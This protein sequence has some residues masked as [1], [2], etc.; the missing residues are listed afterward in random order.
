MDAMRWL[1]SCLLLVT[2]CFVLFMPGNAQWIKANGPEGGTVNAILVSGGDTVIIGLEYGGIYRSTDCGQSWEQSVV[3]D[4]MIYFESI[5]DIVRLPGGELFAA[6]FSS[7]DFSG[8]IY[9][10]TDNGQ[11][12]QR[13]GS[14]LPTLFTPMALTYHPGTGSIFTS[15][16]FSTDN[17]FRSTDSGVSWAS[18]NTGLPIGEVLSLAVDSLNNKIYAA[19]GSS[20]IYL[21]TNNGDNWSQVSTGL[22]STGFTDVVVD[23]NGTVFAG[24]ENWGAGIFRSTD[25]G[26]SWTNVGTSLL[27][28][29]FQ[30]MTKQGGSLVAVFYNSTCPADSCN[31]NFIYCSNDDGDSWSEIGQ[32]F[33]GRARAIAA[34]DSILLLGTDLGMMKLQ[35][36]PQLTSAGLSP[37]KVEQR[38]LLPCAPVTEHLVSNNGLDARRIVALTEVENRIFVAGPGSSAYSTD[39]G[40]SWTQ[41]TTPIDAQLLDFAPTQNG[42]VMAVGN[43]GSALRGVLK[44]AAGG[45]TWLAVSS[46]IDG[47]YNEVEWNPTLQINAIVS[48][49]SFIFLSTDGGASFFQVNNGLPNPGTTTSLIYESVRQ[50]AVCT[51]FLD[52]TYDLSPSLVWQQINPTP[53]Y[54]VVSNPTTGDL[55]VRTTPA[56]NNNTSVDIYEYLFSG[57][58]NLL[59]GL[60]PSV[61]SVFRMVY[62][63][64]L[65]VATR[66]NTGRKSS[67][68]KYTPGAASATWSDISSGLPGAEVLSMTAHNDRLFVGTQGYGIWSLDLTTDVDEE[69]GNPTEYQLFQNYPNP[70]NPETKIEYQIPT[71]SHVTIKVFDLLG[72]EVVTL[73][74]EIKP[75][76]T[77]QMRFNAFGLSSGIYLYKLS[78]GE[79]SQVR[80]MAVVK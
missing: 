79:Y 60:P 75:A 51:S 28:G 76:G 2:L 24:A 11:T 8:N 35:R 72:R 44:L 48:E 17:L 30:G 73:V 36:G 19:L 21:S 37:D 78:A 33:Y 67:I 57:G 50:R 7:A 62:K 16:K 14:G 54:E 61:A 63:G 71:I 40:A 65:Y 20:K 34:K 13:I 52:G 6:A 70:F 58:T 9:R 47:S 49:A 77:Y 43:P 39:M 64:A 38:T 23:D 74:D 32:V 42:A 27:M 31:L 10:S 12:W 59:S 69:A 18:S 66:Q 25:C 22:P 4:T 3:N 68:Y 1:L 55:Y 80:K 46:V 26:A 45:T 56:S 41:L 15:S 29:K 5:H 53:A